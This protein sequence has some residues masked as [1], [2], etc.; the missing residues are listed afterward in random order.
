MRL[1]ARLTVSSLIGL[2][3]IASPAIARQITDAPP[4]AP[5]ATPSALAVLEATNPPKAPAA[6]AIERWETEN[7]VG[8]APEVRERLTLQT[9]KTLKSRMLSD[10]VGA[11]NAESA[12]SV[13]VDDYLSNKAQGEKGPRYPAILREKL[14]MTADPGLSM[15][16]AGGGF[17]PFG[18]LAPIFRPVDRTWTLNLDAEPGTLE[19]RLNNAA[20]ARSTRDQYIVATQ[21]AQ[22][23]LKAAS[24]WVCDVRVPRDGGDRTARCRPR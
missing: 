1:T 10:I 3:L 24:G 9:E 20:L 14:V 8:V 5:A 6:L 11:T 7:G 18:W 12:V 4:E 15:A 16:S 17:N 2:T 19:F 21:T 22:V 13:A 23:W